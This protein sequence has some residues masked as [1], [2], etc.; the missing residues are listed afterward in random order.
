MGF[1]S[2]ASRASSVPLPYA[3][4]SSCAPRAMPAK[5]S[6]SLPPEN[7]LGNATR[8][9]NCAVPL[10]SRALSRST[11]AEPR[12]NAIAAASCV[13][14]TRSSALEYD[15]RASV[16]RPTMDGWRTVPERPM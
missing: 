3:G 11:D 1:L 5:C 7:P 14:G 10:P 12:S 16:S 2:S 13:I 4:R 8:P 6:V 15:P 9:E